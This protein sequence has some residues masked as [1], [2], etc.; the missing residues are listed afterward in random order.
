M[1]C[2]LSGIT[3]KIQEAISMKKIMNVLLGL[4]TLLLA[5]GAAHTLTNGSIK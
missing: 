2:Y 3:E 1:A 4:L 5:S